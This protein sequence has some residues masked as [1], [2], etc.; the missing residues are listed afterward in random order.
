MIFPRSAPLHTALRALAV[1]TSPNRFSRIL[2]RTLRPDLMRA[3]ARALHNHRTLLVAGH[4]TA[5]ARCCPDRFKLVFS[6]ISPCFH[7]LH[8]RAAVQQTGLNL[9]SFS[10]VDLLHHNQYSVSWPSGSSSAV[11]QQF[12][13]SFLRRRG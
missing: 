2:H 7:Y 6:P 4:Q 11:L 9:F 3:L 12:I 8:A 5:C 1:Q 10:Y 13:A